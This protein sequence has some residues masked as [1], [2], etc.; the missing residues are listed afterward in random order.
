LSQRPPRL[1]I[2]AGPN[3][4]GKSTLVG[5]RLKRHLPIVNPDDI[6]RDLPD[7]EGRVVVAGRAALWEREAL[8]SDQKSFAFET[9]LSGSGGLR[10]MARCKAAGYRVMF[11]YVGLDNPGLSRMRV[12][13][14]V[15]KGGHD[16]PTSDI[17]RRYPDSMA[18][19][20]KALAMAER[21]WVIDNSGRRRRLI[22]SLAHGRTAYLAADL[23]EWATRAIPAALRR[24]E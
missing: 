4:A 24:P 9:T 6:A 19:L 16:V 15:G 2:I 14:R 8:L 3:G 13:D 12:L 23:P 10:F 17:M 7:D 20:A 5:S 21:A 1:W 22:L 18:N 11:V